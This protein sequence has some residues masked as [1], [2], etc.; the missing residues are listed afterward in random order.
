MEVILYQPR[1][2][3][4][5]SPRAIFK[6]LGFQ[7]SQL[8]RHV[9]ATMPEITAKKV[10]LIALYTVAALGGTVT[11]ISFLPTMSIPAMATSLA[12]ALGRTALQP[13]FVTVLRFMA[14]SAIPAVVTVC[15]M[16]RKEL[17]EANADLKR[18]NSDLED[19]FTREIEQI[20]AYVRSR[21][22]ASTSS[23]VQPTQNEP[24]QPDVQ[25][26]N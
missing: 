19:H 22:Q 5:S 14:L 13:L 3:A 17:E 15:N 20:W 24:V 12:A 6:A 11:V 4:P 8:L 25:Q 10:F 18:R 26:A 9:R 7:F 23:E 1:L 2:P 16:K 21:N